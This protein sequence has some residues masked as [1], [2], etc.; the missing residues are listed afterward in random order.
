MAITLTEARI[1]FF[2]QYA[3][4]RQYFAVYGTL[5]LRIVIKCYCGMRNTAYENATKFVYDAFAFLFR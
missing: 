1:E 2:L 4:F 5:Q 3:C